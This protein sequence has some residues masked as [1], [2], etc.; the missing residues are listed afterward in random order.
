M[1][2]EHILVIEDEGDIL[3]L[4]R[5][6]LAREGYKVSSAVSGEAGL[7]L[8]RLESPALVLLDLML[9]EIDGLEVCKTLKNDPKT[10]HIPIVMLTAKGEESDIV[11]GLEV[12][13]EDYIVKP[14]SPKVLIAR[15]RAVLRRRSKAQPDEK[16]PLKVHDMAIHPGRHE[17]IVEGKSVPLTLTEFQILHLL[18]RRPGWVFSRDQILNEIRGDEAYVTDRS[19]DVQIVGLR[20]KLGDSGGLIETVRG[21]GYKLKE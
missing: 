1:A 13:A 19:I 4:I 3:E 10:Q 11:T 7:K 18:A 2:K 21:V 6:N 8:A 12:G 17:V 20:K 14:F 5:F 16:A 15:V 9:P